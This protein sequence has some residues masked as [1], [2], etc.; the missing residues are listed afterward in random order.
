MPFKDTKILD[1]NW[2]RK[3]DKTQYIIYPD[4]ESFI[5]LID[6]CKKDP[7]DHPQRNLVS[8]LSMEIQFL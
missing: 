4:L 8:M 1:F 7:K 6:E 3:L 2:Y 5:K